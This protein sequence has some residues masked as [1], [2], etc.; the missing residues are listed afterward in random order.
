[1]IITVYVHVGYTMIIWRPMQQWWITLFVVYIVRNWAAD[2]L[3]SIMI[4]LTPSHRQD[5]SLP[6]PASEA[7]SGDAIRLPSV[8]TKQRKHALTLAD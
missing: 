3:A 4:T 8:I 1:M 5:W 2:I 7:T 6:V